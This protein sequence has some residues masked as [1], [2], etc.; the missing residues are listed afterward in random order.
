MHRQAMAKVTFWARQLKAVVRPSLPVYKYLQTNAE[1]A[2][3]KLIDTLTEERGETAQ[4]QALLLAVAGTSFLTHQSG[5]LGPVLQTLQ[6]TA[7]FVAARLE[8][9]AIPAA[10]SGAG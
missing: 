1:R 6:S 3:Q 8:A 2:R 7:G 9:G 5:G 10:T 4:S